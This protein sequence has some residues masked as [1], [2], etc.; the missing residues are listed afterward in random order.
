MQ[1]VYFPQAHVRFG[2]ADRDI[3]PPVGIYMRSWGAAEAGRNV[4]EGV[5]RPHHATV[6]VFAPLEGG[7]PMALV[8]V[9][10]G[11]FQNMHDE[12]D[13]RSRIMERTGLTSDRL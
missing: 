9:D 1:T 13:I 10:I 11:W 8:A 7:Q 5:H 3:T 2:V 12:R 4:S 6:A